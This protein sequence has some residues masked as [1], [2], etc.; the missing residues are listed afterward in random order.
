MKLFDHVDKTFEKKVSEANKL[1]FYVMN[2][3]TSTFFIIKLNVPNVSMCEYKICT[4]I[5]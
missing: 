2:A 3:L 5:S 4:P 1:I